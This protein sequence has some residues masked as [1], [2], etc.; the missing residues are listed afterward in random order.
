MPT[1]DALTVQS[2]IVP[3]SQ[4]WIQTNVQIICFLKDENTSA[5]TKN[6][7]MHES[8]PHK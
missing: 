5:N 1:F 7:E 8:T 4:N 2:P 6:H 3:R